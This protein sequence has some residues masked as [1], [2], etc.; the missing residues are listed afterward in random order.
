[1]TRWCNRTAGMIKT[2]CRMEAIYDDVLMQTAVVRLRFEV[3]R[4]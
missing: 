3:L 4:Y 1:M 2:I